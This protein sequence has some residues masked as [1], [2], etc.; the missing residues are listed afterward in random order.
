[1]NNSLI[2]EGE[3]EDGESEGLESSFNFCFPVR[4]QVPQIT[5][6]SMMDDPANMPTPVEAYSCALSL[7]LESPVTD[8]NKQK[9][10]PF[11]KKLVN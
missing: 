4:T 3:F 10:N 11:L 2:V 8:H 9:K 7:F 6:R 5:V 1:M